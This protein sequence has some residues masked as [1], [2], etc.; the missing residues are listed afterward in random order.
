[1][2]LELSY[3][4]QL[5]ILLVLWR[6]THI[7]GTPAMCITIS[8]FWVEIIWYSQGFYDVNLVACILLMRRLNAEEIEQLTQDSIVTTWTRQEMSLSLAW[9]LKCCAI[10]VPKCIGV[11]S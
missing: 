2:I 7:C 10:Y 9:V 1:M 6:L 8:T 4:Y 11:S 5:T 3:Q